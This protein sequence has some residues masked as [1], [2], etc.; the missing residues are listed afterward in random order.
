MAAKIAPAKIIEQRSHVVPGRLKIT[1]HVFEVPTDWSSPETSR[2]LR[3][4]ARSARK[5][6]KPA[7]PSS[8]EDERKAAQLPFMLFLQGGPGF[9]CRSPHEMGWTHQVLERGYQVLCLDQRGT[10]LSSPLTASTLGLRGDDD[11]Q[12]AY[13]RKFRA[14]SIVKDCEAVRLALTAD[15]PDEKKTWSVAGQSFGGFCITTYLSFFPEGLREA[16]FFG[17]LPPLVENPDEVYPRTFKKVIERNKAYY[18]K[19]PEDVARVKQIVS[20][21]RKF[22]DSTVRLP[23]EGS[24]SARRF[25]QLGINMGFHGGIDSTHE[26]VLRASNDLAIFGHLTRPTCSL[27]EQTLPFDDHIVYAILHEPI[28][29]QG[30]NAANWSAHRIQ[31]QFPE[32]DLDTDGPLHF[33]GEM[34]FPWMLHDYAELRGVAGPAEKLAAHADW[35]ALY[36]AEQLARNEVPTYAAVYME[37][38]YVDFEHSMNTARAI[39]GC[40]TFVTNV[41]YHDAVRSRMDDVWRNVWALRDEGGVD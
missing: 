40:R 35:P 21:L 8:A 9:G 29:C 10:G 39:K 14:D 23:S 16:F 18:E 38:M 20:L 17:G 33:T 36:D 7:V 31:Q 13:L 5:A 41:M 2:P 24:L 34:V 22:G 19:Y 30:N 6:E 28:Y 1:E 37:D 32:F 4:F 12:A 11:V 25:L 3:L 15:Y 27:I 26:I